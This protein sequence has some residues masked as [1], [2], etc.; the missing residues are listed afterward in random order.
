MEL[1]MTNGFNEMNEMEMQEVDGGA[2]TIVGAFLIS[3]GVV[4]L[5]GVVTGLCESYSENH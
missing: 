4:L 1:T 2:I 3:G 5:C